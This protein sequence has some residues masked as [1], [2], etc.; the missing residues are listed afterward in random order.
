MPDG[1]IGYVL[2]DPSLPPANGN[3]HNAYGDIHQRVMHDSRDY[4]SSRDGRQHSR[5][6]RPY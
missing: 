2:V 1:S 3:G 5:R 4:R 6:D